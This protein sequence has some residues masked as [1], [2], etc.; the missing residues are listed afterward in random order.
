MAQGN[1]MT[2]V[3]KILVVDDV[4]SNR[5]VLRDI[6]KE[7]GYQPVLVE[8]GVQALKVVARMRPRLIILDVAMPEMDG[9]QFCR[10]MKDDSKTRDIPII[11]VSAFDEPQD[12]V[13]GFNLGGEDYITKPFIPEVV[14][15]R[16]KLHLKLFDANNRLLEMNRLLQKSVSEQ[17]VQRRKM[18][19][20]P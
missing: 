10:I 4:D 9:H 12:I 15:A 20:M 6:I 11:F 14:K 17:L 3:A 13:R 19:S 18:F 1:D 8:N 7:M 16:L 5:F 2:D